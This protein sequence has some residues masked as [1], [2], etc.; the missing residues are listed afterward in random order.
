LIGQSSNM[1]CMELYANEIEQWNKHKHKKLE[2]LEHFFPHEKLMPQAIIKYLEKKNLKEKSDV[3]TL[4]KEI[5]EKGLHK[6]IYYKYVLDLIA[7]QFECRKNIQSMDD[8]KKLNTKIE[9][10]I[11]NLTAYSYLAGIEFP[12]NVNYVTPFFQKD[13]QCTRL[14]NGIFYAN[15]T[16]FPSFKLSFLPTF[17]SKIMKNGNDIKAIYKYNKDIQKSKM[18]PTIL[19]SKILNRQYCDTIV[20]LHDQNYD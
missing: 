15:K 20:C 19:F 7:I 2:L 16:I 18:L 3:I 6:T 14:I 13:L 17:I 9:T 10:K 4:L 12:Q 8:L 11:N 1:L 5:N